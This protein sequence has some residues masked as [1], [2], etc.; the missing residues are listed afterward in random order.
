MAFVWH[1]TC[2]SAL[3]LCRWAGRLVQSSSGDQ[4]HRR[5]FHFQASSIG[6]AVLTSLRRFSWRFWRLDRDSLMLNGLGF[7]FAVI[8]FYFWFTVFLL[9]YIFTLL[10]TAVHIFFGTLY[11]FDRLLDLLNLITTITSRCCYCA[12]NSP[13]PHVSWSRVS[14][15]LPARSRVVDHG[16]EL[17][18]EQATSDD[19]GEYRC[20]AINPSNPNL[21][22]VHAVSVA[23][24]STLFSIELIHLLLFIFISY[25]FLRRI[26]IYY[27]YQ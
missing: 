4:M 2:G 12:F 9:S 3:V 18:I 15:R 11:K 25:F 27:H 19:A 24:E 17:S 10:S 1:L 13:T 21:R 16:R 5:A 6:W 7:A 20:S 26:K 14:G 23:V 8:H 22:S